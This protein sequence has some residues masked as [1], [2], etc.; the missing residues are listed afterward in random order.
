MYEHLT[1]VDLLAWLLYGEAGAEPAVG[2]LAVAWSVR[3]SIV[4][5]RW[6]GHDVRSVILCYDQYD[7]LARIPRYVNSPYFSG[8]PPLDCGS[9]A[10]LVLA[11][12][13]LDP[14][15]GATHFYAQWR[16]KPWPLPEVARIGGHI[17]CKEE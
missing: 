10:A 12:L 9:V 2:Q 16:S 6:W 7:G 1:D 8:P 14:T 5:A 17:F 11:G 15:N 4:K 3:N 13:T